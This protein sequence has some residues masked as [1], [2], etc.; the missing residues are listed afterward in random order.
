MGGVDTVRNQPL[1]YNA[2]DKR[3]SKR[4]TVQ[5]PW[6]DIRNDMGCKIIIDI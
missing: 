3:H 6:E 5:K 4:D 1:R 2:K